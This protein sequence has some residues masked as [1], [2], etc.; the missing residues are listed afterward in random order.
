MKAKN[1]KT[2][3][4]AQRKTDPDP[5]RLIER[6]HARCLR[7]GQFF[8]IAYPPQVTDVEIA[9]CFADLRGFTTYCHTLQKV[10]LDNR[11]QNFLKDYFKIYS[12]AVLRQLWQSEPST[13]EHDDADGAT[14]PQIQAEI[15]RVLIPA[16][17]KNLGDGV[18]LIWEI[19]T[20]AN[21]TVQGMSMHA[22]LQVVFNVYNLFTETFGDL[23][24][25][26]VDA[27]SKEVTKLK[28]GFGLARGHAWKLD[29]GHHVKFDYAGSI[30]NLAS[31]LQ[32]L[33]RPEGI[34][35]QYEFSQALFERMRKKGIGK[36]RTI[37]SVRGI[38][39]QDVFIL[40]GKDAEV[41]TNS[42]F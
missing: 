2:K 10:S 13:W 18:M 16:T 24:A 15:N 21:K 36:L 34:V 25:A 23:S 41:E 30:V 26:Q 5:W 28:I 31:R 37:Q 40:T 9:V 6:N 35:C 17:Y 38:G 1:K 29:F 7:L 39:K 32:D 8:D 14:M 22:I 20:S 4:T 42:Y 12:L 33:A 27:Y 3:V 11:I 19:P